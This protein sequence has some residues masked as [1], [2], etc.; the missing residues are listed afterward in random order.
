MKEEIII[1]DSVKKPLKRNYSFLKKNKDVLDV[2]ET[3]D[4]CFVVPAQPGSTYW[5]VIRVGYEN[6]DQ[7]IRTSEYIDAIAALMEDRDPARWNRFISKKKIKTFKKQEVVEKDAK[8]W[9]FRVETNIKMMCRHSGRHPYGQ[10]LIERGHILR[11]E[12]DAFDGEGGYCLRT[13][14]N[15]PVV[16]RKK[17]QIADIKEEVVLPTNSIG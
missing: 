6:H 13:T 2:V 8:D 1:S 10:R 5:A 4:G 7:P 3:E 14:T 12:P 15:V 16:C 17:A 11:W 9:R